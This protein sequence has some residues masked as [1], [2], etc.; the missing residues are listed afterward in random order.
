MCGNKIQG[1]TEIEMARIVG[2]DR[3]RPGRIIVIEKDREACID[4]RRR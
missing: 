4:K 3:T 1:S 2:V